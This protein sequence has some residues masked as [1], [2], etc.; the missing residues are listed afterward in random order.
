MFPATGQDTKASDLVPQYASEISGK[1]ILITGVSPASL[2]EKFVTEVAVAK[3]AALI[4]AGRNPSKFQQLTDQLRSTYPEINVKPLTLDLSSF[5]SV[6]EAAET[7]NKKWTDIPHIDVLVCNAA[8]MA[9][10]FSL[11]ADGFE[12]HLQTNHLGHFLLVNLIMDKILASPSGAP[13][14][15]VISS[16]GHALGNMRWSDYNF[17]D[18]L[19]YDR[20]RAY[21]QSKTANNLMAL[22]LARRL[23]QRGL[24][25]YSVHPGGI[26]GTNL[27]QFAE[28]ETFEEYMADLM[29]AWGRC[30]AL[31]KMELTGEKL[32]THDEGVSTYVLTCFSPDIIKDES[33]NGKY[34]QDCRLADYYKEEILPHANNEID[35][36]R[37]WKLS[38]KLVGQ[39][40]AH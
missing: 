16:R 40:F 27:A 34:F 26:L 39:E 2:G 10:P 20:W 7:V 24:R 5:A 19:H 23:G 38:E 33:L 32:K 35:A 12:S 36:E 25:A 6:R 17:E 13:R 29:K 8:V 31:F 11:T 14:V 4:L 1:T 22:G 37:L 30:G 9:V 18:G 21:A 3:P 15:V 28:G